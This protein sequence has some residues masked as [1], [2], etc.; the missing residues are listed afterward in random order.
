[1]K[2]LRRFAK[3]EK[4]QSLVE[5]ALAVPILMLLIGGFINFGIIMCR[6]LNLNITAQEASRYAGLGHADSEIVRYV[7]DHAS[8][9]EPD[10]LIVNISPD[11]T[12]RKSGNYVTVTINYSLKHLTPVLDQF[13]SSFHLNAKSTVRVE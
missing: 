11:G 13:T 10:Q 3:E 5:F 2:K 12:V 6:Y 1:M 7:K 9:S 4:G 8:V